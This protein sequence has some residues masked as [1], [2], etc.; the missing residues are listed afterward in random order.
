VRTTVEALAAILGGTQSLHTNAYDEAWALPTEQ[1]ALIALRTQQI[2][3]EETGVA[4]V[5]DPLGG[6]YYVEWLTDEMEQRTYE[7]LAKIEDL[8]G[9][10]EALKKG[11]IQKEIANTSYKYQRQMEEGRKRVVGV[12]AYK[13]NEP[14]PIETLRINENVRQKQTARLQD[15]RRMRDA[16][17]VS[18]ALVALRKSFEDP[19]T[20]CIYPM[21]RAVKCYAT[22][23][24]IVDVGRGVFGGWKEPSIL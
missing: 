9:V 16:S 15:V 17:A 24:E 20:N 5:I 12:N 11:F 22:L 3:A 21:L 7:Y 23:G 14:S 8:G 10:L 18:R 2:M 13:M 4:S 1:A 19:D 6:S